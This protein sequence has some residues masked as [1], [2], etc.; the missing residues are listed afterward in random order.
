MTVHRGSL[1]PVDSD[2]TVLSPTT[3]EGLS[4]GCGCHD[5]TGPVA[6][7]GMMG[8]G[9]AKQRANG[10]HIRLRSRAFLYVL[11]SEAKR[12][13]GLSSQNRFVFVSADLWACTEAVKTGVVEELQSIYGPNLYTRDNVMISGT[14]THSGPGG[15]SHHAF[16]N[17]QLLGFQKDNFD[18][19]CRGIVQSIMKANANLRPATCQLAAG[20]LRGLTANRSKDAYSHNPVWE[21]DAYSSNINQEMTLMRFDSKATH[22]GSE[23]AETA[24]DQPRPLGL[25]SWFAIHPTSMNRDNCLVSGDNKGVASY[26]F[27]RRLMGVD[28]RSTDHFVAAFA[29]RSELGDVTP[30]EGKNGSG[31]NFTKTVSAGAR[32]CEKAKAL[33]EGA[34]NP[35]AEKRSVVITELRHAHV[36]VDFHNVEVL[37][38]DVEQ[39]CKQDEAV[40][41]SAAVG[42]INPGNGK[43]GLQQAAASSESLPSKRRVKRTSVAA[44]GAAAG[45]GATT[46]GP[47]GMP[48]LAEGQK[49]HG[50]VY[51]AARE[52][53]S[54]TTA[55]MREVHSP[56]PLL[57]ATGVFNPP[58]TPHVLPLQLFTAYAGDSPEFVIA[59][60]P[61][62]M[63][64]MAGRRLRGALGKALG[65]SESCPII[66]AGLANAYAGYCTTFEEYQEQ[67][68]EGGMTM[69]GP[70]QLDALIQ[71][72][73]KLASRVSA[74]GWN[75]HQDG[76]HQDAIVPRDLRNLQMNLQTGVVADLPVIGMRFGGVVTD[77][78]GAY[79]VG[80]TVSATFCAGHPKNSVGMSCHTFLEVQKLAEDGSW[81][82][83]A[84][85][86]DIETIFH[87]RRRGVAASE[88]VINW[89]I[90]LTAEPGI[91]RLVHF[92][93]VRALKGGISS[94]QGISKQFEVRPR[95]SL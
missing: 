39:S 69:F 23:A 35:A 20:K 48:G 28:Y 47:S 57:L 92:G 65:T 1:S 82:R 56:K 51:R 2:D 85:D 73:S 43:S 33:W 10:L 58:W 87:W 95:C 60:V 31:S 24:A 66:L 9:N 62:E 16:Y 7:I 41:Q 5:V 76:P 37:D 71:E 88:A 55:E 79:F 75:Q 44:I 17:I 6:Q 78:L 15:Y 42:T 22:S 90:P 89:Q 8:Y 40:P 27:E 3:L 63:S 81:V 18:C 50:H 30:N 53:L 83:H 93:H 84:D 32:Q 11:D 36:Y 45:A 68:Y 29:Q 74:P 86:G 49:Q 4:I 19:V 80:D 77:V 70:H 34:S 38:G 52:I 94:Y 67:E 21:R 59:S 25:I 12:T 72:F 54:P 91:F 61:F 64:T 13:S 14:H 26:L 46:D